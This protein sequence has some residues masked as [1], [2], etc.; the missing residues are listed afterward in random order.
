M[1]RRAPGRSARAGSRGRRRERRERPP[2]SASAHRLAGQRER[3]EQA[4]QVVG[5]PVAGRVRLADPDPPAGGE[6]A[7]EVLRRHGDGGGGPGRRV[8][9]AAD[10]AVGQPHRDLPARRVAQPPE[11]QAAG[12]RRQ[13]R[14]PRRRQRAQAAAGRRGRR[15]ALV[16]DH[17]ARAR[18][19]ARL[20]V[21]RDPLRRELHRL[22]VDEPDDLLGHQRVPREGAQ[23]GR[24]RQRAAAP[25]ELGPERPLAPL[26]DADPGVHALA[27]LGEREAVGLVH[28]EERR[29]VHELV[30]LVHPPGAVGHLV[31]AR[32][33]VGVALAEGVAHLGDDRRQ[34]PAGG[35]AVEVADR[36][37]DVAQQPQVGEQHD[38]AARPERDPALGQEGG[39]VLLRRPVRVAQVVA[40]AEAEDVRAVVAEQRQAPVELGQ[41]VQVEP[42]E[43]DRVAEDVARRGRARVQQRALVERR[44]HHGA[45]SSPAARSPDARPS[46]WKPNPW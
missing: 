40:V 11:G 21:E 46:S 42:V 19:E 7:V 8:A 27:R 25:G 29:H 17:R 34:L 5:A 28:A 36:V 41:L 2:G 6:A 38:P 4:D 37:E 23:Q 45:P 44:P 3:L 9:A 39:D 1:S 32:E 22:P 24:V 26:D 20:V 14:A 35:V 43:A 10:G 30:V 12:D 15:G 13:R 16:G 18:R 33:Q 31:L